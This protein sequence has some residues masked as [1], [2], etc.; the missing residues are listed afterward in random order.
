MTI[1]PFPRIR[2]Y[3]PAVPKHKSTHM[4]KALLLLL[5]FWKMLVSEFLLGIAEIS[6]Y[7]VSAAHVNTCIV[8]LEVYQ[9]LMLFAG[10][11]LTYS[12]PRKFSL[13][14]FYN[15]L[16]LSLSLLLLLLHVYM[17]E[18]YPFLPNNVITIANVFIIFFSP[19]N[20]T[21]YATSRKV[22]GSSPDDVD[23]FQFT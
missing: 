18:Y 11:L 20:E 1:L 23:F 21:Y 3:V 8:L 16:L 12:E 7:S 22:A 19:V 5:L 4:G 14:I 2:I 13:M 17:Y 9:L 6:L 10:T 15:M